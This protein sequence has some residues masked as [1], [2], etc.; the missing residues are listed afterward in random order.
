[1]AV[2][3][4]TYTTFPQIYYVHGS[5]LFWHFLDKTNTN[6]FPK[7]GCVQPQLK[8]SVL[9]LLDQL[10]T[11]HRSNNLL[12]TSRRKE[13]PLSELHGDPDNN[14]ESAYIFLTKQFT[15]I[16]MPIFSVNT[17]R[18]W[19][20]SNFMVIRHANTTAYMRVCLGAPLSGSVCT[21]VAYIDPLIVRI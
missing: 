9:T 21:L 16:P 7:A 15:N 12:S 4:Y 19:S 11:L 20:V 10:R 8:G 5:I 13:F 6:V 3:I 14:V 17:E 18:I 2:S 1:V